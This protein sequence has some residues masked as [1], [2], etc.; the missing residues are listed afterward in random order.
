MAANDPLTSN[1]NAL[2]TFA[3]S[4]TGAS[5]TNL[6][7]AVHTLADGYGQGGGS[8]IEKQ[9]NFYDYDGTLVD[10]YTAEEWSSVTVLPDNPSHDGLTALGWNWTKAQIDSQL[11]ALPSGNINV[12]QMYVTDDGWTRIYIHLEKGRT[13]PYL[14][15]CV[16]GSVGVYWGDEPEDA[17]WDENYEPTF[18]TGSSLATVV[19]T[20]HEYPSEGD[21]VIKIGHTVIGGISYSFSGAT[22][23]SYILNAF[24]DSSKLTA[25]RVYLNSIKKIEVGVG[26]ELRNYCFNHCCSLESIVIP[27]DVTSMGNS[28][29]SYCSALKHLTLPSGFTSVAQSLLSYCSNIKSVS[30]PFS[31]TEIRNSAFEY[32]DTLSSLAMPNSVTTIGQ[33]M[34]QHC[35]GLNK[36]VL[37]NGIFSLPTSAFAYCSSLSKIAYPNNATT[38]QQYV[39]QYCYALSEITIPNGVTSI[40]GY[41]F[42]GCYGVKTYYLKPTSPPTLGSNVFRNIQSD[43]IIY[44]PVGSLEAYQTANNWS[45]YAFYMR[46]GIETVREDNCN[47]EFYVREFTSYYYGEGSWDEGDSPSMSFGPNEYWR[48]S[49]DGTPYIAATHY[50]EYYDAYYLGNSLYSDELG[51]IDDGTGIPF[52]AYGDSTYWSGG[53]D[54]SFGAGSHTVKFE[55]YLIPPSV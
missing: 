9:I 6:S 29:L 2:T 34:C 51:G 12:G 30:L 37:P 32:C 43:C 3:N 4:V 23:G 50:L 15:L 52:Y 28:A 44:V 54:E 27:T 24:G 48:V 21:Y 26:L 42:D 20:Q 22:G 1:I 39:Q 7:D 25:S 18:I 35:D 41:A 10:S 47:F 53:F 19:Y 55:R 17:Y 14:G 49:I 11:L 5:D 46:E 31:I 13:S 8:V 38:I 16:N 40:S 36:I 33:Y 45:T